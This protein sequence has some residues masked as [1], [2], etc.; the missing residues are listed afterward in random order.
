MDLFTG[1]TVPNSGPVSVSADHARLD[2]N[3]V[4]AAL[5][6]R[7]DKVKL[8]GSTTTGV[9]AGYWHGAVGM[10]F[11]LAT[12]RSDVKLQRLRATA[13]F[14]MDDDLFGERVKID[15]GE[16]VNASIPRI[17][18]PT[19][20]TV[21]LLAMVRLPRKQLEPYLFAGPAYLI[22][23]PGLSG[24]WG[25]RAGGGAS[26]AL[27]SNVAVFAEYRYTSIE[28]DVIA[29]RLAGQRDGVSGDTGNIR[30]KTLLREHGI[31]AGLRV[32]L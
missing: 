18:L 9:R 16:S 19:T 20:A 11:D 1:T 3:G 31:V 12:F 26:M 27:S 10:A 5:D 2:G 22:T 14:Q 28:A 30:V 7:L 29:G 21:A 8:S 32:K 17:R 15:A 4:K 25:L 23:T 6:I 24:S 13:N